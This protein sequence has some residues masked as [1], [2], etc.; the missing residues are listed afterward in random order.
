M[1]LQGATHGEK[2]LYDKAQNF[3]SNLPKFVMGNQED[4]ERTSKFSRLG[5]NSSMVNLKLF[6]FSKAS[7]CSKWN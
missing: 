6:C 5:Q 7:F 2:S 3:S 4:R 1:V